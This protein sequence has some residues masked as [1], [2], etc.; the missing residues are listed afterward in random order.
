MKP[1]YARQI[2]APL[3]R[4]DVRA[5]LALGFAMSLLCVLADGVFML[6]GLALAG[7]AVCAAAR[8]T[9][10]QMKLIA[11]SIALLAWGVVFS[12]S[13]FYDRH[14]RTVLLWI[15]PPNRWSEDGLAFYAQGMA[16]GLK[17]SLR[18]MAL[19]LTGYAVCFTTE[20]D[21]FMRGL[22]AMRAPYALSFMA[23]AAIRFVPVA[24]REFAAVRQAMRMKGYRPFRNG[25]RATLRTEAASLRPILAAT[26]RRSEEVALSIVSRGFEVE[27]RRT[28]L[29]DEA[30]SKTDWVVAAGAAIAVAAALA[31]KTLSW[32]GQWGIYY[33]PNLR[34]LYHAAREWL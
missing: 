26:I 1:D 10:A 23:V 29:R 13:L 25:V 5:K 31:L 30:M 12:Q 19:A 6:A 11:F 21:R 18:M 28:S 16:H 22:A 9:R 14:P 24:A 15:V 8:P 27:G 7:L 2:Q 33:H 3:A 4:L 32:L 20:P 17:Q 34:W